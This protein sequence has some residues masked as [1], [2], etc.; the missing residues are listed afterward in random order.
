MGRRR[1]EKEQGY[2]KYR[3]L[4]N[5]TQIHT[6]THTTSKLEEKKGRKEG[7]K[8]EKKIPIE[9]MPFAF[10]R[11]YKREKGHT[12]EREKTKKRNEGDKKNKI[13]RRKCRINK[14]Q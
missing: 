3:F 10:T 9:T 8:E 5:R 11:A 6:C 2:V 12:E 14:Y 7:R 4:N 13:P 1:S